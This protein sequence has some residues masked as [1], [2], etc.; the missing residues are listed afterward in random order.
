MMALWAAV[1]INIGYLL[2]ASPD[3]SNIGDD[4]GIP[5]TPSRPST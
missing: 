3:D 4:S 5:D 1:G 2:P